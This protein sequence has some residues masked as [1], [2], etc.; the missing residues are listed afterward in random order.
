MTIY[1]FRCECT[2][3]VRDY[4]WNGAGAAILVFL[5][6]TFIWHRPGNDYLLYAALLITGM[7]SYIS[8][9][10]FGR[11]RGDRKHVEEIAVAYREKLKY[12]EAMT[13]GHRPTYQS[14]PGRR[15]ASELVLAHSPPRPS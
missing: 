7:H 1:E 9:I 2:D 10:L 14:P 3:Y 8:A 12:Q 13:N 4:W 5:L 6:A 15:R 11:H